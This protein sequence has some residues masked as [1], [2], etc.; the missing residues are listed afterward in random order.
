[1]TYAR[2]V[3]S[4]T[5]NDDYGA[6]ARN[7]PNGRTKRGWPLMGSENRLAPAKTTYQSDQYTCTTQ[8]NSSSCCCF[9]VACSSR[10]S[11]SSKAE[12]TCRPVTVYVGSFMALLS[13]SLSHSHL[14]PKDHTKIH[15]TLFQLCV[16]Y[17]EGN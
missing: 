15:L 16:S 4:Q 8:Q 7:K 5:D 3:L 14:V 1:M 17:F 6:A 2:G 12:T 13:L 9:N 10:S 11:G